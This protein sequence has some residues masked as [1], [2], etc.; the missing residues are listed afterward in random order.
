M[1]QVQVECHWQPQPDGPSGST[2]RASPGQR[3]DHDVSRGPLW[4]GQP[5]QCLESG[6]GP[7]SAQVEPVTPPV[8]QPD[9]LLFSGLPVEAGRPM[10]LSG[11]VTCRVITEL[12][13]RQPASECPLPGP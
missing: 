6:P 11:Q 4:A 5:P 2:G 8:G 10:A 7:A 12:E 3:S 13:A 9:Y 1:T